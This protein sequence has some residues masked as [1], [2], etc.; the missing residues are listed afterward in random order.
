MV[1]EAT[2]ELREIRQL[3]ISHE[4]VAATL[5]DLSVNLAWADGLHKGT[6][7]LAALYRQS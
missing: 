4:A 7:R 6:R 5:W 1:D 3:T 2:R